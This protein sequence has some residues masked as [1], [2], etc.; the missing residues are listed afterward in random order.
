MENIIFGFIRLI[1]FIMLIYFL[2][3]LYNHIKGGHLISTFDNKILMALSGVIYFVT[4]FFPAKEGDSLFYGKPISLI[5][6]HNVQ[7]MSSFNLSHSEIKPEGIL[8]IILFYY[9]IY[10]VYGVIKIA[11]K[12]L[13]F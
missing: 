4:M 13:R 6:Q 5:I 1:I 10:I 7:A 12:K 9:L 8:S 11:Y 2:F 3:K